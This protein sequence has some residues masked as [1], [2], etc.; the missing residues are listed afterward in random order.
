MNVGAQRLE[1]RDV[2][3]PYLPRERALECLAQQLVDLY[4]ESGEGLA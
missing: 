3:D 2:D 4:K 1:R